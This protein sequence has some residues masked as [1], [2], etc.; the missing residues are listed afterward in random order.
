MGHPQIIPPQL[1]TKNALP[2]CMSDKI[3]VIA[4]SQCGSIDII[5]VG[6]T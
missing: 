1:R 6:N 2:A 5:G 3:A 4:H